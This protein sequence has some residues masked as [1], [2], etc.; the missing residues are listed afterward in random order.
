[1]TKIGFAAVLKRSIIL[2]IDHL[3]LSIL[4]LTFLTEMMNM[5]K[6]TAVDR[7]IENTLVRKHCLPMLSTYKL[8][9]EAHDEYH[10]KAKSGCL[11]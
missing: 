7:Q 3:Q 8:E 9:N 10:C 1:M 6:L 5:C 2:C 11:S 4:L